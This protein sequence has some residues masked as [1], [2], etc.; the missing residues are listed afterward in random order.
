MTRDYEE[1][2]EETVQSTI[3]NIKK[4]NK[5]LV[6]YSLNNSLLIYLISKKSKN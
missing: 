1:L 4:A 3:D 6:S 5:N 2:G